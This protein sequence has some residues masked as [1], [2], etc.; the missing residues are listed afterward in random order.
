MFEYDTRVI[1]KICGTAEIGL[2]TPTLATVEDVKKP[3][4]PPEAVLIEAK[5]KSI[6]PTLS[7]RRAAADAG[8]SEGR[9]RQIAKGY[10]SVTSEIIAPVR[11]PAD[12]VAEMIRAIG[13]L[14]Y[15]DLEKLRS[16]RPDVVAVIS[17]NQAAGVV[18][19][20]SGT[21]DFITASSTLTLDR[22]REARRQIDFAIQ[23]LEQGATHDQAQ[24]PRPQTTGQEHG[25]QSADEGAPIGSQDEHDLA[26]DRGPKLK[27]EMFREWDQHDAVDDPPDD[28]NPA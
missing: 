15:S 26:A 5:R 22:L 10:Q 23:E 11:A 24:E 8:I 4:P 18:D 21:P 19:E 20:S 25:G 13:G 12:T 3:E 2:R 27:R 9:W 14:S 6:R 7:I 17:A 28:E 1:A 16:S